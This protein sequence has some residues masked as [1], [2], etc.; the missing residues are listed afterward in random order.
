MKISTKP[1][2]LVVEDEKGI[3]ELLEICFESA[4]YEVLTADNGVLTWQIF[5]QKRP[6][7]LI[8]DLNLPELS[9]FRLLE[10]IRS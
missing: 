1:Q 3:Q 5:A 8:L 9:G 10:L 7:L 2:V 6:D 4:D